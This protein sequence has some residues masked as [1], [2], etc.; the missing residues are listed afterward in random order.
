[1]RWLFALLLLAASVARA[2]DWALPSTSQGAWTPNT[3]EGLAGVG[4]PGG[5]EQYLAGGVNDRAVT[6]N[7]INVVT[8][9]GADNTGASNVAS[10]VGAAWAAANPGDVI[11]F[12][13][14]TYRFESGAIN[15]GYKDNITI[16]GASSATV[17]W[18]IATTQNVVQWGSPG[19]PDYTSQTVTG[20][21]TKGTTTLT[22]S[23]TSAFSAGDHVSVSYENEINETRIEAGTPPVWKSL[24]Q[25]E[26]RRLY[27]KVISKTGST[28]TID[29]GLP[30]DATN[31]ALKV[32][33]YQLTGSNWR[34]SGIGVEN[35]SVYFASS[36]QPL[37]VFQV[38]VADYCWFY[39]VKFTNW[40]MNSGSGSC[41]SLFSAYRCE[42]QKCHFAALT[43]STDDGAIGVADLTSS[44]VID[45][46]FGGYFEHWLYDNGNSNNNV[47]AYNAAIS[48]GA[49]PPKS[50]FHNT[51]PSLN[52]VEGNYASLHQSDG[53]HGS[54]SD[55]S[56]YRN[57]FFG[58]GSG[59]SGWWSIL[60][61]RF[62]RRYVIAQNFL[63]EDGVTS[64][65]I[66]WGFPN[67]NLNADGFAGP[68]GLSDQVGEQDYSQPG[69]GVFEYTIVSGDVSAGDFWDDWEVTGT[70]TTRISDTVAVITVSGGRWFTGSGGTGGAPLYPRIWWNSNASFAGAVGVSSVTAVSGNEVTMSFPGATLPAETTAL[71]VYM[72]PAG[73]QEKD[74]DVQA[75]STY[76]HNYVASGSGTGSV[77]NSSGDTFPASLAWSAKPAWFGSKPWPIF[78]VNDAST[79]DPERLPAYHRLINGNEDYLGGGGAG[80]AASATIQ[81]LN[82][83]TLN[84]Q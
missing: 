34:T 25:P 83:G 39:D 69:Y 46:T 18:V 35:I 41:I 44:L 33:A 54:S 82:V 19:A 60:L 17:T 22:V 1:M 10:A 32:Y 55:N 30:A 51:H 13:A 15:T 77:E 66:G 2:A 70:L 6:G 23:D 5:F 42:V 7:V 48:P 37:A 81:T 61:N 20:T 3:D 14:G 78:N 38:T 49:N 16:R 52:L 40:A 50:V 59:G 27:A 80:G 56:L 63:G 9:H 72:G 36:S 43:G 65:R 74:L 71:R 4:I 62:K 58:G 29:P 24:G 73:W 45:N 31:L 21:K 79:A 12:P 76:V 11:Y 28:L 75:S 26:A 67:F 57:F 84:I 53:Y 64:G 68:T 8:A 47:Y